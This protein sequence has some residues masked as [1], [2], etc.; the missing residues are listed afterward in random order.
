MKQSKILNK[1]EKSKNHT[2]IGQAH[3]GKNKQMNACLDRY[4][5]K[6]EQDK[7]QTTD[8]RNLLWE[9]EYGVRGTLHYCIKSNSNI[10]L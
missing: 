9:V 5:K 7:H 10:F 6:G 4:A 2:H 1:K 3:L 8:T